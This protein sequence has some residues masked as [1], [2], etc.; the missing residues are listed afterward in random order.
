MVQEHDFQE[1]LGFIQTQLKLSITQLS[2]LFN[3]R[4]KVIYDWFDGA[5]PDPH[6][7]DKINVIQDVI[8]EFSIT[9][10]IP[11]LKTVWHLPIVGKSFI[12][13]IN[14]VECPLLKQKE[15]EIKISQLSKQL[16]DNKAFNSNRIIGNA[17]MSDIERSM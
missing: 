16:I 11:K 1:N 13:V 14:N 8:K 12:S 3:V 2:E 6:S 7:I 17:H 15:A 9:F 10:Y 4:R 5:Q